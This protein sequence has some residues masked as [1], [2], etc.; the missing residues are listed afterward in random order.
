M[1]GTHGGAFSRPFGLA[2]RQ[3]T[4]GRVAGPHRIACAE[5]RRDSGSELTRLYA[6][7]ADD[8]PALGVLRG[9]D[10]VVRLP[11][12]V[13]SLDLVLAEDRFEELRTAAAAVARRGVE[14]HTLQPLPAI[15]VPGK[16]VCVG[17]NYREHVAE[18][19]R[20]RPDRPVLFAKFGNAIIADG[21]PVVRP[22]GTRALDLE[23][24]LGLVIGRRARRVAAKDALECVAGFVVLNDISARDWQGI[25]A[26]LDDGQQGDEQWLRAKGSDTFLPVGSTFVSAD[27]VPAIAEVRLRSWRVPGSGPE[28]GI[29]VAMQDG[30]VAGMIW[31]V[32]ELIE[33][34][35]SSIT[36]EPGDL[37]ATGTPAGVGVHRQPP[38]F[39]EPG[40]R[41]ICDI[42]GIGRV[43]N[44]VIDWKAAA[45]GLGQAD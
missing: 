45:A 2:R 18:T 5:R 8:G 33:I 11:D 12:D 14:R 23:V 3:R 24:E 34:I 41:A 22:E 26:A 36:L 17:R 25:A 7:L 39:L 19:G 20:A 10:R 16:I 40:D 1:H 35:S 28:A 13:G 29:P 44:P 30:T 9:D 31:S 6:F 4:A 32:P 15:E 37:V 43:D 27:E 38:I 42:E 21:E